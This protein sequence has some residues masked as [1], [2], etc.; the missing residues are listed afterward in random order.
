MNKFGW[1][2][3]IEPEVTTEYAGTKLGEYFTNPEVRV[4]TELKSRRIF[5][6]LFGYGTPEIKSID[7]PPL[8]YTCASVLGARIVFPE[9]SSPMIE[10]RVIQDIR[11]IKN[12]RS[13]E[14]D[15][16]AS[17]GYIPYLI[18]DYEYL[19]AKT[20]E[21]GVVPIFGLVSQSPLGTAILL[22]G[23]DIFTDIVYHPSEIKDLLEI[24]TETAIQIIRFEEQFTGKKR[25]SFGMDD[26]FGGLVSP[27]IY[28]EFNFP[29]M[30]RMYEQFGREVRG[31]HSETLGR[32]HLK[33][34][35]QLGITNYDAW[36]YHNLSVKD[37]LAEL[38]G[39]PFVWNIE[40]TRDLF[41]DTPEQIKSKF[42]QAVADGAPGIVL[43]LCA[44]G[45]PRETIRAF[46]D[47]AREVD[48]D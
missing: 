6:E 44:R 33:F 22:R 45:V 16:V 18:N 7:S 30:K 29:Y 5:Y 27:E 39:N 41:S 21:T 19:K 15:D 48:G 36:V 42:K 23:T 28:G 46:I 47:V 11:D 3:T 32:G 43:N 8:F 26:D 20:A 10:N 1:S 12:L 37:V 2:I 40:T 38:P 34:L 25:T 14:I 17:S 13:V 24:I 31:L 35:R 4:A 9:D